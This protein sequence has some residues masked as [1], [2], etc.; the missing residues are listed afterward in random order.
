MESFKD[1]GNSSAPA[2]EIQEN[3]LHCKQMAG[4]YPILSE[5]SKKYLTTI[6]TSVPLQHLFS[7]SQLFK[8]IDQKKSA[9]DDVYGDVTIGL[10]TKQLRFIPSMDGSCSIGEGS[11]W[12]GPTCQSTPV[13]GLSG[14][15]AVLFTN[16]ITTLLQAQGELGNTDIY[17]P[18]VS[19]YREDYDFI[20]VGGGSAGA[21]VASRLSEIPDWNVLLIEAGGDP[22]IESEI[23]LLYP[24]LQKSEIDWQYKTEPQSGACLGFIN[25]QCTWPRGKVLGGSSTINAM[26]YIRGHKWDYDNWAAKGN[27]GWSY[28]EVLPYFKKSEKLEDEDLLRHENTSY[29]HGTDGYLPINHFRHQHPVTNAIIDACKEAGYKHSID[30][31]ADDDERSQLYHTT[32]KDGQRWNTAKAFLGPAKD[33]K[34]LHVTKFAQVTKILIDPIT[35]RVYG[36]QFK[37]GENLSDVKV[38]KEVIL[39]A[40]SI[41]SPQIL[42][43]SGI[44][45]KLHLGAVG[46]SP[47]IND[48]HVGN[49]L[50][51]HVA[52][53]GYVFSVNKSK[54]VPLP[55]TFI[56]DATY[57]YLR[58]RTGPLSGIGAIPAGVFFNTRKGKKLPPDMQ[59][60]FLSISA[61]D[62]NTI[63]I[64]ENVY[65]FVP[66]I[67]EELRK[68]IAESDLIITY[69][70][71]NRPRSRGRIMLR[72]LDP[73]EHPLIFANYLH[74]PDDIKAIVDSIEKLSNILD[75]KRMRQE[76]AEVIDLKLA[77]CRGSEFN[78]R[79]YWECA[80]REMTYT[81][82]HPSGTCKMGPST[83]P[84]SV[85]DPELKVHGV[86]GLRV[87][88]ASI[89]PV[90][91][92]DFIVVGGGSAGAVVASR[93]SEIPDWNV[94][95]IEAGGDP[96][97]ESEIPL[98]YPYLQKS[99]IDWQYKT[100]PQSG[101]CL[102]FINRQCTWPRGKVLG[103]SSTINAMIYIRG[104]KWDYDNWAAKGNT[105]WSYEEVLPYFKK[106][107]KLEDEDLLR[108]EN[109]SKYHGTDG[110]LPINRFSHKP[111][112][113]RALI[114]ASRESGYKEVLDH[115][116]DENEG[117]S[118]Y[119]TNTKDGRRWNTAKAFLGPAKERKNLHVTKFSHVTKILIDPITNKVYGV[120]FKKGKELH[121]VKVTKEV[122]LSAGAINSPQILMLSGI[123]PKLH[124]GAVGVS[125][126]IKD[127]PVGYNLQDHVAFIGQVFSLNRSK[128]LSLSPTFYHD[129]SYEY[130]RYRTGPLSGIGALATSAFFKTS[131]KPEE[132]PDMQ[133]HFLSVQ[134]NDTKAIDT[135][136]KNLGLVPEIAEELLKFTV[137]SDIIIPYHT[138]NRPRSRGRIMLKSLD[139]ME[140][141]LIFA[142]SLQ[143]SD[144]STAIVD[145]VE[146]FSTILNTERM[147]R[148]EAQILDLKLA[149]C[150]GSEF[151]T[152]DYWEC[153]VREMSYT[154]YHPAG[155]CKMGPSTDPMAVVDPEL[156]VHGVEGLRVAD[157]SIMP[158]VVT[159]N[160]NAPTIMIG[161]KA[162]DLTIPGGVS[163]DNSCTMSIAMLFLSIVR[164][165]ISK[166]KVNLNIQHNPPDAEY[167]FI[168]VGGGSAGCVLANRLSE[169]PEWKVLLLEAGGEE[170]EISQ[171]PLLIPFILGEDSDLD[172]NYAVEPDEYMCGGFGCNWS[173]GKV[174][175]G[176]S[177]INGMLY[178]RGNRRD[179]DRWEEMGNIGWGY[180]EVLRYFKKSEN[181]KNNISLNYHGVGGYLSVETDSF[182]ETAVQT[183]IDAVAKS[184]Y[185]VL[186][187]NGED[188]EGFAIAQTTTE[189]GR[190][191]STNSAFLKPARLLRKNL[192]VVTSA[193]VTK[194]IIDPDLKRAL[195]VEFVLNEDHST[196]FK[197]LATKET[198]LSAGS[199][200]SPKILM[201]SGIGLVDQLEPLGI[202]VVQ[203]LDVG[204]NL[205][206]HASSVIG[207]VN[208]NDENEKQS[209]VDL[210]KDLANYL[211]STGPLSSVGAQKFNGFIKTKYA[212]ENNESPDIQIVANAIN[213]IKSDISNSAQ[214]STICSLNNRIK[215]LIN[216]NQLIL[217]AFLLRPKSRGHIMLKSKDP[218]DDPFI[219]PKHL[220]H[221]YDVEVL[222]E[223]AMNL[224]NLFNS[225]EFSNLGLNSGNTNAP[226]IMIAEKGADLIKKAHGYSIMA[227]DD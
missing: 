88:D 82:Y 146:I 139:P 157:A 149:A 154:T 83:D 104:H 220:D 203:Q 165:V 141:P 17:P 176:S 97:I 59:L 143:H 223:G 133:M 210:F 3:T 140:H 67:T 94:L 35:N 75:T 102:G 138:L 173:K 89:M 161:E 18:D 119:N 134:A 65:N 137:E 76:E 195:G 214:K 62:T 226:T 87:A 110:Y 172:W 60:H 28:E 5:I 37:K 100:E 27:T 111:P 180:D 153:A 136:N 78:T 117:I 92:Y 93:L 45:P 61:N 66:E 7:K 56:Y 96:T 129:A 26:I 164:D 42:M 21:V 221:P 58:Y 215:G 120:E 125:P 46:V 52:F 80:V 12:T 205:H 158:V 1:G 145:S 168:I 34:N 106:S 44:G 77:A 38:T 198:I 132:P 14:A 49:N 182:T 189:N 151:N 47:I 109:T 213:P 6:A 179:Y 64:L 43:L 54:A 204:K 115:N 209:P 4:V 216:G 51:D 101:A 72:N 190:R 147:R 11:H 183:M 181:N 142:N 85:V 152:R 8:R 124:L 73:M 2:K 112:I 23:P 118:E 36:V 126:I 32:S 123:G 174:L 196:L 81:T 13:A 108:H 219:Y 16:L 171:V 98:L 194:V 211:G 107:E 178:I 206:E 166:T 217:M 207:I 86:E 225:E 144:D 57:E 227:V 175:G 24:Y 122:I 55:P 91:D 9:N 95:L 202:K 188:Q 39:S 184:G 40:G 116:S 19:R 199:V 167:D 103:G 130:L 160:T 99:E 63:D 162:A 186:D 30:H 222:S 114:E 25:R 71:L 197:S 10:T 84:M 127:L 185:K 69:H 79:D 148:E 41:N 70:T 105:G 208:F 201:L 159:G 33:R 150:R 121:V 20:V 212:L 163:N 15:G 169:V 128:P 53:I 192:H 170:P 31:N 218:F 74:H 135:F 29:Y 177:S 224:V 156:R 90:V 155:T 200:A 48:L 68:H 191:H 113:L 193:T 187:V 50:Q 22:T 131:K